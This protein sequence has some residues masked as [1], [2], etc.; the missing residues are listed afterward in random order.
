MRSVTALAMQPVGVTARPGLPS[1]S[2]AAGDA[3]RWANYS[4]DHEQGRR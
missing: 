1:G 3:E 2:P 4:E